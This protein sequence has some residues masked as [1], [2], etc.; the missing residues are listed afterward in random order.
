MLEMRVAFGRNGHYGELIRK[1]N[2]V[3]K[4]NGIVFLHG[5]ISPAVATM[6]CD[7]IN[8]TVRRELATDIDKVRRRAASPASGHAKTGRFG[9]GVS[10]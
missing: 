10:L 5:G 2:A 4:V 8:T 7:A 1:L 9:I 6:S 3:V